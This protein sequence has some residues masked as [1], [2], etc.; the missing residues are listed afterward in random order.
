LSA[1]VVAALAAEARTLGPTVRRG[2]GL[3]ATRDGTLVAVSGMGSRAA[4]VA[5]AALVDAGATALVSWGMAG[6]LDPALPAGAICLPAVVI[7]RSDQADVGTVSFGTDPH[8]REIVTAAIARRRIVVGGKLL[9]HPVAIE[10]VAGKAAAFRETGA[11]AVDMESAAVAEVAVSRGLQFI[12]VRVIV[13]TAS[14]TL[15]EAVLAAS[16]G[17]Q[18]RMPRLLQG[19]LRHPGDIAPL[20][21][22]ARRYRA[23]THALVAVARTGTLAPLAFVAASTVRIA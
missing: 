4:A 18:V 8:W 12:A 6:G 20:L 19:L 22:L 5:A 3:L 16:G 1:G 9:T 7:S 2:D 14:D 11:A 21:R 13:D 23:A 15:P 10:D 17:G